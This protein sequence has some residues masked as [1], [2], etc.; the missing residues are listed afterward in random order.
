MTANISRVIFKRREEEN[1]LW[2]NA[3]VL[4]F[5]RYGGSMAEQIHMAN[6][7]A[8]M[9]ANAWQTEIRWNFHGSLQGHYVGPEPLPKLEQL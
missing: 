1:S 8:Q 7:H 5:I 4:G 3:T 6:E 2:V 9:L